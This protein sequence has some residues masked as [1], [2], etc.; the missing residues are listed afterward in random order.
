MAVNLTGVSKTD[1]L[2]LS[3]EDRVKLAFDIM[4]SL[5]ESDD[6]FALTEEQNRILDERLA[7]Y[8]ADPNEG[9]P[10]EEVMREIFG[11]RC[12]DL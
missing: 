9:Q 12:K 10:W 11:K 4:E 6:S 8:D 1:I 3:V 7:E 2:S 5:G